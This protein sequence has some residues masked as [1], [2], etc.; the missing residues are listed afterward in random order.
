[1]ADGDRAKMIDG[2]ASVQA[3]RRRRPKGADPKYAPTR[4]R[5]PAPRKP[6]GG[7]KAPPVAH[8]ARTALPPRYDILCY[9]CAYRFTHTGRMP[10]TV[11]C[12]KCREALQTK[13]YTLDGPWSE[14]IA[15]VGTVTVAVGAALGAVRIVASKV[16]IAADPG[17]AEIVCQDLELT[18]N[19]AP[20][21]ARLSFRDLL[22]APEGR[23]VFTQKL[24][25]RKAAVLGRLKAR[26][27]AEESLTVGAGATFQGEARTPRLIL[28]DGARLSAR[29]AI[30]PGGGAVE[31]PAGKPDGE[32]RPT[33]ARRARGGR[34]KKKV[35]GDQ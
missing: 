31:K 20:G 11:L 19:A 18:G 21:L 14:P 2:F 30:V 34:G 6:A 25:C 17:E 10:E 3:V 22:V 12:P 27:E 29:L 9:A 8:A 24:A 7:A 26:L 28:E 15:T 32:K 23:C 35:A 5:L 1:M 16:R 4:T 13:A 33:P